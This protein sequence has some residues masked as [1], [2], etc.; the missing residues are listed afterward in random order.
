MESLVG[1]LATPT[2]IL[3]FD[4]MRQLAPLLG[5]ALKAGAFTIREQ[6]RKLRVAL[7]VGLLLG[8]N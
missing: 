5:N 1:A 7:E 4:V 6:I 2:I 8:H 3:E